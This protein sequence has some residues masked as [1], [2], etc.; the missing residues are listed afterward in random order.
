MASLLNDFFISFGL[1]S[2]FALV[3]G[4]LSL[5]W[6]QPTVVGLLLVGALIGPNFIGIIHDSEIVQVFAE[7]GAA[8]LL[9]SIGLEFS[10]PKIFG[11]GM[12]ALLVSAGIIFVGFL[13]GYEAGVF[14]LGLDYLPS[15]ALGLIFSFSSTAIFVRLMS[16]NNL[17]SAPPIPLLVSVLVIEDIFAVAA[18]T[19]FS[20]I[21]T[22]INS[23]L[24]PD[25]LA[26]LASIL[27]SI[28]VMGFIYLVFKK[29][30]SKFVT[31]IHADNS[32][33]FMLL[34]ALG[35]CVILSVLASMIGLTPSVGAFLA[36]SIIAGQSIRNDVEK[37]VAPFSLAFSSFF[38][39]SIG[40]LI[41]PAALFTL[42][43]S[44]LALSIIFIAA[45]FFSVA[46]FTYIA[47]FELEDAV[48][49]GAAMAV[50]GE[51]SLLLARQAA[52]VLGSFDIVSISS[53]IVL[54]STIACSFLL[55]WRAQIV[56]LLRRLL[57]PNAHS[58]L[59]AFREYVSAVIDEFEGKGTFLAVS[60]KT[61]AS[62]LKNITIFVVIGIAL[63]I[64]RRQFS[65]L[66]LSMAGIQIHLPTALLL[67]ALL[68][69][70]FALRSVLREFGLL[71]DAIS[72]VF[73]KIHPGGE[74]S[75][76]RIA[77]DFLAII[78]FLAIIL[79][80][81]IAIDVLVLPDVFHAAI[82]LPL[83]A[84]AMLSW[85]AISAFLSSFGARAQKGSRKGDT[86]F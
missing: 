65:D 5:R 8:L 19:F 72:S 59:A 13:S 66:S 43:P 71:A 37:I 47:G 21:Q 35:L 60:R 34:L 85:D 46:F 67:L 83:A 57:T 62:L 15:I 63:I 70:L 31:Y 17:L 36:G 22:D 32:G 6:R 30:V 25:M 76:R 39:L 84:V 38:F 45:V 24:L 3:G 12:R 54:L 23:G 56:V 51:F 74:K 55:S 52:P 40:L 61:F 79:L 7:L 27:F 73:V 48:L 33:E 78:P 20:S 29:I 11:S 1:L 58:R 4:L 41:S 28:A 81:P 75:G 64:A 49:S 69:L 26:I 9:F 42:W 86:F 50:M 80:M 18:L 44:V 2:L 82:L 16:S 53:L 77:R 68:P 14:L 10:L